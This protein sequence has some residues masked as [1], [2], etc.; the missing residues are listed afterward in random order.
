MQQDTVLITGASR[1][2]GRALA[3]E[4]AGRGHQVAL[5]AREAA[6]LEAVA[7]AIRARGG[8]AQAFP[9]DVG[10]KTAIVPLVARVSDALGPVDVLVNNASTL[11]P[12]PLRPLLDTECEDLA[13][14]FEVNLVGPF[15]LTKAVAGG[16]AARGRG[17]VIN[18]SSD[19]AVE[20]YPSWG[21]YGSS[22]A[23]LD[24]LTRIWGAELE[25]QGVRFVAFDPGEMDTAMHA[26]A[27]PDAD[28]ATLARPEDVARQLA[29]LV[30]GPVPRRR[31]TLADLLIAK[32]VHP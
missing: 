31:L 9:A 26:A 10:D 19:A 25:A 4:L 8:L 13:D 30:A 1:G 15:R 29:D 11:G 6:P 3:F 28:P 12:V 24:H 14:V 20:A 17:L 32:E 22:K 16:M 2:L 27:I 23:A 21:S 18:V 7:A 5:V